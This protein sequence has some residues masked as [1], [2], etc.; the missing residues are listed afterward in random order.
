MN[1]LNDLNDATN[2]ADKS[3]AFGIVSNIHKFDL[4]VISRLI[5]YSLSQLTDEEK[6]KLLGLK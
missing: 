2:V 1:T 6:R 5:G 3:L 4:A